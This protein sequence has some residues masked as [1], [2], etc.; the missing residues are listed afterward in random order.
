MNLMYVTVRSLWKLIWKRAD[1]VSHCGEPKAKI[2]VGGPCWDSQGL[3]VTQGD[4]HFVSGL[5]VNKL[6]LG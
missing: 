3:A 2:N 1:P 6:F 4:Q 5:P